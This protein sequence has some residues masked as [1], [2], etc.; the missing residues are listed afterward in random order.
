MK[1]I[2]LLIFHLLLI[3]FLFS[4]ENKVLNYEIGGMNVSGTLVKMQGKIIIADSTFKF[5]FINK[6]TI[7]QVL[8]HSEISSKYLLSDGTD[9][10]SFTI[11]PQ[12]GKIKGYSYNFLGIFEFKTQRYPAVSYAINK[13]SN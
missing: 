3:N 10:Y 4:Q 11:S 6:V 5:E 13:I 7:Y 1:R 12:N 8:K 2:T 9:E